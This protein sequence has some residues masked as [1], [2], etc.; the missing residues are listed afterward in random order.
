MNVVGRA[1]QLLV[2]AGAISI[3]P[4]ATPDSL[5]LVSATTLVGSF[6]FV[7]SRLVT[8]GASSMW[9]VTELVAE[10]WLPCGST[11]LFQAVQ[12]TVLT[13]SPLIVRPAGRVALRCGCIDAAVHS[14]ETGRA[15]TG[16]RIDRDR[17]VDP[18]GRVGVIGRAERYT[19]RI[20]VDVERL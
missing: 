12:D 13:P 15:G 19:D 20:V 16:R 14:A 7:G 8:G 9:T 11:A 18:H 6:G 2:P 3:D 10:L 1:V 5:S 4:P 17:V